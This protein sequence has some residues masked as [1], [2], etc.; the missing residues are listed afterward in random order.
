MTLYTG[1]DVSVILPYTREEGAQKCLKA[2][3][4][5]APDAEVIAEFDP[6]RI[7][8]ARMINKLVQK[9]TRPIVCFLADDTIPEPL[10]LENALA[11]METLPDGWGVV[12]LA[13]CDKRELC[14]HWVAH[15]KMLPLLGGEFHHT[16]YKHCY[17]SNEL[18][19]RSRELGRYV[20]AWD[21]KIIHNNPV[22]TG[23]DFSHDGLLVEVYG[24]N[25]NQKVDFKKYVQRKRARLKK[26]AI[27]FP[28]V[29]DI[30]PVDFFTTF[31]CMQKP[32]EYLLLQPQFPHGQWGTSIS[33]ARNSLVRQAMQEGAEYLIMM[34][35]DQ[36]YPS[37][38]LIK[39]LSHGKDICGTRVHSR[40]FPFSP[41]MYRG[42]LGQYQYIPEKE[43]FSGDLVGV[44]A[45]GTGCL[46]IKMAVFDELDYPWF[47]CIMHKER[48][49]G[50]D[51]YFC[52][53]SKEAGFEIFVDTSIKVGHLAKIE[54]DEFFYKVIKKLCGYDNEIT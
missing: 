38:T 8:P 49:V 20:K 19:D 7:G 33:D 5:I 46:L 4:A 28:L 53:K 12:G 24:E 51:I 11:A 15:K 40:W 16:G 50:E 34:D 22:I 41:I 18:W 54:I 52:N 36:T 9:T 21:A 47:Q 42:E 14:S 23:G 37:D 27:G 13:D 2:L 6:D 29:D 48:P 30:L 35:T 25:G 45:T 32:R 1:K 26:I 3:R 43:M 44:D 17:G 10:F 39:L 31:S